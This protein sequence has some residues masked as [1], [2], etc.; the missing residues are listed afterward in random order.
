MNTWGGIME[1]R[2]ERFLASAGFAVVGASSD[3]SKYGN[4]VLRC[5]LQHGMTVF[6]VNPREKEVEGALC[7]ASVSELP[8]DVKSLS[9]VTPPQ[10]TERIVKEAIAHGIENIWMQPGAESTLAIQEC[11]KSGVNVIGDGSCILVK[12]GYRDH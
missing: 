4:K 10:V 2:I 7:V 5:Y 1:K 9:V 12:L 8:P 3:R 11:E 6:G